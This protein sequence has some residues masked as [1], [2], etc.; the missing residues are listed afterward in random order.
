MG[1]KISK[2]ELSSLISNLAENGI[3]ADRNHLIED[4][5]AQFADHR[6]WIREYVVN[7][8]D[9]GATWCRISGK[10]TDDTITIYVDDNGHG[11]DEQGVKDFMTLF[12]S[13]KKGEPARTIG[14]FGVGKASILAIPD[15]TGLALQ[16]STGS[17]S[18]LLEVG[19]LVDGGPVTMKQF[20]P[21][22]PQGTRFSVS[23]RVSGPNSLPAEL[24]QLGDVL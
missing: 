24:K 2:D 22:P 3:Q 1:I 17:E 7:A 15:L 23:Y 10:Q 11:M 21:S 12:K 13:V 8:Y 19:S 4:I 14:R 16:T 9:A 5:G 18:W 20:A 6:E